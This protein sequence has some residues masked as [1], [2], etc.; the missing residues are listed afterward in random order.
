MTP[1]RRFPLLLAALALVALAGLAW[2]LFPRLEPEPVYRGKQLSD[3][4]AYYTDARSGTNQMPALQADDAVRH[5][6]SNAVPT[7]LRMLRSRDSAIGLTLFSVAAR[8]HLVTLHHTSAGELNLRALLAFRALG[9][10]GRAAVPDLVGIFREKRS[11][12]SQA[13][14]LRALGHIGPDAAA[15]LPLLLQVAA[16]TNRPSERV[17]ALQW[18]AIEALGRIGSQPG[19][20]VPALTRLLDEPNSN[21]RF[22]AAQALGRLGAKAGAAVPGLVHALSDKSPDV[23]QA[24]VEAI[25]NI[26]PAA[27]ELRRAELRAAMAPETH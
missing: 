10:N 15:A 26:D 5:I 2:G 23:R 3:W 16:G 12:M 22:F 13:S 4:L 20:T 6:G 14:A 17:L 7:L 11:L 1:N 19:M 25:R 21:T 27:A 8:Q 24:A 9:A 18:A